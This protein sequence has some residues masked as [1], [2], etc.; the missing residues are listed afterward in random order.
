MAKKTDTF[1]SKCEDSHPCEN[2]ED[3]GNKA[4]ECRRRAGG[5]TIFAMRQVARNV[6]S[7]FKANKGRNE[8]HRSQVTVHEETIST[9]ARCEKVDA[10]HKEGD[11]STPT[12]SASY[13]NLHSKDN[14]IGLDTDINSQKQ[15]EHSLQVNQIHSF[16]TSGMSPTGNLEHDFHPRLKETWPARNVLDQH[17]FVQSQERD[18]D[19]ITQ[20]LPEPYDA[21][22]QM[23]AFL[24][25]INDKEL[26]RI[27]D[28]YRPRLEDAIEA[29]ADTVALALLTDNMLSSQ[30]YQCIRQRVDVDDRTT[31]TSELL[32]V[33]F[34]RGAKAGRALWE[35]LVKMQST[36]PKL[37]GIL[38]EIQE[39]GCNLA[40]EVMW[41]RVASKVPNYMEDIYRQHKETLR[42]RS[43]RLTVANETNFTLEEYTDL[44]IISSPR[45][46][47]LVEHEQ[48]SRGKEHEKWQKRHLKESLEKVRIDQ[49]FRSSFGRTSL[50]GTSVLTGV[51]GIGK[52]TV[53]HKIVHDWAAG[54]IYQ[55]FNFVFLFK[56]RDFNSITG[57]TSL[58]QIAVSLYPYLQDYIQDVWKEP[59]RILIILDGLDEFKETIDFGDQLRNTANEYH[60]FDPN[61]Q[62]EVYDIVRCLVQEKLLKDCSMLITSRPT[63][64]ESLDEAGINLW[65]EV[66]GFF[67]E[68]RKTFF[69][70]F[71]QNE[72]IAAKVFSYVEQDD[73]LYTLCFNPCYCRVICSTLRPYFVNDEKEEMA[74]PKTV[75]ALFSSYIASLLNRWGGD[76]ANRRELLLKIGA[77]AYEGIGKKKLIFYDDDFSRHG[78]KPSQFTS[79]FMMEML[80][81]DPSTMYAVHTFSHLTIQ[82]FLAALSILLS[83]APQDIK[84]TLNEAYSNSDGR[85]EIFLRFLVGLSASSSAE[86]LQNDLSDFPPNATREVKVWLRERLDEDFKNAY[87]EGSKKKL[88]NTF[89]LLFESQDT[90]FMQEI[91]ESMRKTDFNG[92]SLNVLDCRVLATVLEHSGVIGEMNLVYCHMDTEHIARL[93]PVFHKCKILRLTDNHLKDSGVHQLLK[94]L[95]ITKCKIETLELANNSLTDA[96]IDGLCSAISKNKSLKH[97]Q[98]YSSEKAGDRINCFSEKSVVQLKKLSK[99]RRIEIQSGDVPI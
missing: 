98:I 56:F 63:A 8:K 77:M 4:D 7:F 32:N 25:N 19:E 51:A 72:E 83:K 78:L 60:C 45:Q 22:T 34:E 1:S 61:C 36:K 12:S 75:T 86:Q 21:E 10:A 24:S 64:L 26:R 88:L 95:E 33:V 6:S 54:K 20:R 14:I 48:L 87:S 50:S 35:V 89:Y 97:L 52:T 96:C 46:R 43:V 13:P 92:V 90:Q 29:F 68:E 85:Y 80:E 82:E 84:S 55:Q 23:R 31:A 67:K 37:R 53:V 30:D 15:E 9:V 65:A 58:N 38:K 74:L 16:I 66:L 94:T 42:K 44:H 41:S 62:C 3:V 70:R 76:I 17:Q 47:S 28:F 2:R 49:L 39:K 73:I 18:N 91:F 59:N 81:K 99:K 71:F 27:T 5:K 79:G 11:G 69:Q 40:K 57:R 93:L